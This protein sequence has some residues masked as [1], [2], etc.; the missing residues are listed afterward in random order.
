MSPIPFTLPPVEMIDV[1]HARLAHHCLGQ[2]PDVVLIYGWPV[3]SATWR[4]VA[5]LLA[6]HYRVHLL[7]LPGTGHSEWDDNSRGQCRR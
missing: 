4:N 2:G 6:R 7:D 3:Y 1:G 5:P